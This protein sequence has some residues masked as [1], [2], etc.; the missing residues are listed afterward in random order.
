MPI[1]SRCR[2]CGNDQQNALH[3]FREMYLGLRD[4]FEYVECSACQSLSIAN[5]PSNMDR[6][7]PADYYSFDHV[8]YNGFAAFFKRRR[9]RYA[10]HRK[11]FIGFLLSRVVEMP[12]YLQW[13]KELRLSDHASIL[14]VGCGS[15][16][17]VV[18]LFDLGFDAIG[19]D[20]FLD[21]TLF[22][23]NGAKILKQSIEE[24]TGLYDCIMLHHSIEH[25]PSPGIVFQNINRLL[26]K[27]G[28][29][30]IRTPLANNASWRKYGLHWFQIDAPRHFV[31]M[32]EKGF[33]RL[34]EEHGYKV[35]KIVY[36]SMASQFWASEQYSRGIALNDPRSYRVH[37]ELSIFTIEEI[38]DFTARAEGLNLKAD[39]DQ[40]AFYLTK[41]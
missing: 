27:T 24:M 22:Y 12:Q 41:A 33:C 3:S 1:M 10:L 20:A 36:D 15:G 4:I 18:N 13:L 37:P 34:A 16:P 14:E 35:E 31:V 29:V 28:K 25:M 40:A 17:L 26:K 19:I 21:K 23:P 38:K 6:Y 7:Y 39:G 8:A 11:S 5:V 32:S 30:L 2:V 9:D